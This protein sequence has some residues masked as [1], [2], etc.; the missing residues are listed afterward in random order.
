MIICYDGNCE[1]NGIDDICCKCCDMRFECDFACYHVFIEDD[2]CLSEV[3]IKDD[4]DE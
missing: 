3:R 4:K 1:R 2:L